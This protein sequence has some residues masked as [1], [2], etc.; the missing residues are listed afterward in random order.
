MLAFDLTEKLRT[1]YWFETLYIITIEAFYRD[2]NARKSSGHV[3]GQACPSDLASA[4]ARG[5]VTGHDHPG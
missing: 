5:R 4:G 2:R 1:G 3:A